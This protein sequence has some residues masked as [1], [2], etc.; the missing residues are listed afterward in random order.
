MER[1]FGGEVLTF[2]DQRR[3]FFGKRP[4]DDLLRLGDDFFFCSKCSHGNPFFDD[5][6]GYRQIGVKLLAVESIEPL[7]R[8]DGRAS[9]VF[10]QTRH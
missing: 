9:R 4:I 3:A 2:N 8:P 7:G 1:S 10:L 5:G 6:V